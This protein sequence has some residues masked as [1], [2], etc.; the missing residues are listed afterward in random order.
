MS[1]TIFLSFIFFVSTSHAGIGSKL[2][3]WF[4]EQNYT[5]STSPGVYEGQSARYL[6]AGGYTNRSPVTRVF[7]FVD[8]Q[9]PKF[10]AGCG[11]IDVYM[12]GISGINAD[13]FIKSLRS[14]GQNATSLAFMLAIQVVSPQLSGVMEDIKTWADK[15][16]S[17]NMDSC[18][19]ATKLVG[20]AMDYMGAKESNC[21]VKRMQEFQEDWNTANHACTTGGKLRDTENYGD[22]N[23]VDFIKGNIAWHVLMKDPYFRNDLD[24]AELIMNITGTVIINDQGGS[25][26]GPS[27]I[28][29][30][31]PAMSKDHST[32]RFEN[33][34][35]SMLKGD[36]LKD[37]L[38]LFKC[39]D[40]DSNEKS[41][42][43]ISNSLEK[44]QSSWKGLSTKISIIINGIIEK[45]YTDTKLTS[46]EKG[47]ISSTTIPVY[48]YLTVTSAFFPRHSNNSR[49]TNDISR[50]IA[51][52]ILLKSLNDIISQVKQQ[53][54]IANNGPSLSSKFADY[55]KNVEGVLDGL[56]QLKRANSKSANMFFEMQKRIQLYEKA[57]MGRLGSGLVTNALWGN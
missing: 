31:N 28:R 23:K 16:N 3:D 25:S 51:E 43:R 13:E 35:A 7:N 15:I 40:K 6:T 18:E 41:C 37:P 29:V 44:V 56:E 32:S 20:G 42:T 8:V 45:I 27:N 57:L 38:F 14:I 1:K 34:Y 55:Q 49:L 47:L 50:I 52:D 22:P 26:D 53:I 5:N 4:N 46:E 30:I 19:A 10:S 2:K 54:S 21:T 33:I 12:G 48:R 39:I 24:F 36:K 9:T 11:G 17:F